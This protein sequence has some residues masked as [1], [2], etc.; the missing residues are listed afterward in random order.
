MIYSGQPL[1]TSRPN[2]APS[3]S[4]RRAQQQP[5]TTFA[6]P[7]SI[8][9]TE[10]RVRGPQLQKRHR[11]ANPASSPSATSTSSPAY[12]PRRAPPGLRAPTLPP[13]RRRAPRRDRLAIN[14]CPRPSAAYSSPRTTPTPKQTG[15]R[16]PPRTGSPTRS[17]SPSPPARRRTSPRG[18][19]SRPRARCSASRRRSRGR[20]GARASGGSRAR[21]R[22]QPKL[23]RSPRLLICRG[24]CR[25]RRLRMTRCCCRARRG[26]GGRG[27]GRVRRG[28]G[29]GCRWM[30]MWMWMRTRLWTALV[31]RLIRMRGIRRCCCRA[32][33][34]R[35]RRC[36]RVCP[37][38]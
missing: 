30:W 6:H 24:R 21:G 20:S 33:R 25:R 27:R 34:G 16:P 10:H 31:G 1:P 23:R 36:M 19:A 12:P 22:P 14:L 8:S 2:R 32:R 18:S 7:A 5:S 11:T 9:G 38:L 4:V 37:S 17:P 13:Q 28:E 35:M 3:G 26:G 29:G 15:L